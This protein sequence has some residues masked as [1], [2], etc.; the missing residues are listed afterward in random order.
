MNK[1]GRG[2]EEKAVLVLTVP[3]M[4]ETSCVFHRAV[5]AQLKSYPE[6]GLSPVSPASY[7]TCV[8]LRLLLLL[9][10]LCAITQSSREMKE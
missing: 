6:E 10:V 1:S 5:C 3:D 8:N 7:G 4:I 2:G 9:P